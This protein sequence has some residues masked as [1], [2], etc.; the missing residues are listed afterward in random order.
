MPRPLPADDELLR[1]TLAAGDD[2]VHMRQAWNPWTLVVLTVL[3]GPLTGGVLFA[4]NYRRLGRRELFAG[5]LA[6]ALAL[7]LV[8]GY[9]AAYLR[10]LE[11]FADWSDSNVLK[12]AMRACAALYAAPLAT[13]QGRRF[14]VF[15]GNGGEQGK[16][17]LIGIV[18]LFGAG[19]LGN[20]LGYGVMKWAS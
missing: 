19:T 17:L 10:R 14:R 20:L 8:G 16:L 7:L 15:T 13:L 9:A 4:E 12:L 3:G 5:V 2:P 1:P 11:A 6:G 18:A